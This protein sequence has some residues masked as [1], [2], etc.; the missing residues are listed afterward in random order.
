MKLEK[1]QNKFAL[2]FVVVFLSVV[3][4]LNTGNQIMGSFATG[5]SGYDQYG[6][7]MKIVDH[8]FDGNKTLYVKFAETWNE[9]WVTPCDGSWVAICA[10]EAYWMGFLYIDHYD[11]WGNPVYEINGNNPTGTIMHWEYVPLEGQV[12]NDPTS[13]PLTWQ[14]NP[15][16]QPYVYKKDSYGTWRAYLFGCQTSYWLIEYFSIDGNGSGWMKVMT[17]GG[18]WDDCWVSFN[19][20]DEPSGDHKI[21]LDS[22]LIDCWATGRFN[23]F[24]VGQW[25]HSANYGYLSCSCAL[26]YCFYSYGSY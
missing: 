11:F 1:L 4:A 22:G 3:M 14:S 13:P 9:D 17:T 16:A 26:V 21:C 6:C 5:G 10:K 24:I 2:A 25:D 20:W 15:I 19:G 18:N 8:Y 7:Y 12:D 23:G